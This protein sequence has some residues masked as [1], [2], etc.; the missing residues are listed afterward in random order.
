LAQVLQVQVHHDRIYPG[1]K[2][3]EGFSGDRTHGTVGVKILVTRAH[4]DSLPHTFSRPT[5]PGYWLKSEAPFIEEKYI[6][7]RRFAQ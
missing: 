4:H 5:P 1:Q 2:Q 3:A 6:C 7:L